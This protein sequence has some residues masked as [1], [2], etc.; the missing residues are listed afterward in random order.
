MDADGE[1]FVDDFVNPILDA[2]WRQVAPTNTFLSRSAVSKGRGLALEA[3]Q[4]PI[5]GSGVPAFLYRVVD[6]K[7]FSVST[8]VMF[9]PR[10]ACDLAGLAV[11][12]PEREGFVFGLTCD[13][14]GNPAVSLVKTE[15]GVRTEVASVTMKT[16]APAFLKIERRNSTVRFAFSLDGKKWRTVGGAEDAAFLESKTTVGLYATTENL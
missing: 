15:G 6:G 9:R 11:S 16:I 5:D 4:E 12:N 7:S 2:A 3:R 10:S 13:A 8:A 14:S 1:K